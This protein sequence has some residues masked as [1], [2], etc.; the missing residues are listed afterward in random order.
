[1]V[2]LSI[3]NL[4]LYG[5][6]LFAERMRHFIKLKFK[7]KLGHACWYRKKKFAK[8]IEDSVTKTVQE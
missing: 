2:F 1:M 5:E 7:M 6:G 3:I 4:K 8:N